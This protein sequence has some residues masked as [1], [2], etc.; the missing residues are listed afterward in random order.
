MYEIDIRPFL[1]SIRYGS[2]DASKISQIPLG[3][4][5]SIHRSRFLLE[6]LQKFISSMRSSSRRQRSS[7]QK[8][9]NH[10][11]LSMQSLSEKVLSSSGKSAPVLGK[12]SLRHNLSSVFAVLFFFMAVPP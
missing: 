6:S 12:L 1:V 8:A 4:K 3:Q 10:T 11:P 7:G 9:S 5:A 2:C